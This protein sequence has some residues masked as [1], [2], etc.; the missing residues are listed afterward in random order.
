MRRVDNTVVAMPYSCA[1]HVPRNK[2]GRVCQTQGASSWTRYVKSLKHFK[3]PPHR[4]IAPFASAPGWTGRGEK[5]DFGTYAARRNHEP[6]SPK[7]SPKYRRVPRPRTP[8]L[9]P[10]RPMLV[11]ADTSSTT[12]GGTKRPSVPI[13]GEPHDVPVG[14]TPPTL[15]KSLASSETFS[16]ISFGKDTW[17]GRAKGRTRTRAPMIRSERG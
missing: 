5:R 13:P 15:M 16:H 9:P 2:N 8:P 14:Y 4:Y 17:A 10:P 11:Y 3:S 6:S 7:S 1:L 12:A